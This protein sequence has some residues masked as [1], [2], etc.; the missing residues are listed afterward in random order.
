MS[1]KIAILISFMVL[2]VAIGAC[3][4]G[5][6]SE[7]EK[8]AAAE[9]EMAAEYTAEPRR[10]QR[11]RQHGDGATDAAY[12]LTFFHA[13]MRANSFIDN[14]DDHSLSPRS[15]STWTPSTTRWARSDSTPSDGNIPRA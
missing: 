14:E 7:E 3:G 15:P 9:V 12:D 8:G 4:G 1:R 11:H 6:L 13:L 2:V 10:L 5:G